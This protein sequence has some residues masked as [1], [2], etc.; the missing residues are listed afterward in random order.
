MK[1]VVGPVSGEDAELPEIVPA[2]KVPS[3]LE[4]VQDAAPFVFQKMLVREPTATD[5]GTAQMSTFGGLV[6][7]VLD[8]IAPA[9][10]CALADGRAGV[11]APGS[12]PT[13]SPLEE[14]RLSK[15]EVGMP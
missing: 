12:T 5:A 3:E 11:D 9:F 13:R 8:A 1:N 10:A 6:G 15:R 14:Q 4:S 2:L 7:T